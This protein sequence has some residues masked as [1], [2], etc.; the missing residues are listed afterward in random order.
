MFGLAF[1]TF[2]HI[3]CYTLLCVYMICVIK[4]VLY[5]FSLFNVNLNVSCP[6]FFS[7]EMY[8]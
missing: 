1:V 7:V 4:H 8:T 2:G 6:S 3:L 5:V